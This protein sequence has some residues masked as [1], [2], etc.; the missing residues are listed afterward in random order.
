MGGSL[1]AALRSRQA[2]REVVGI[3]RRQSSLNTALTLQFVHRGT[4]DLREGVSQADIVV[5]CTPVGDILA[6]IAAISEWLKPG[7]LLMDVGS[8]KTA[9]CSAL[10]RLPAAV[11]PVGGHPMCGKESSGLTM[12]EPDLYQ[13][14][15]FVLCPLERTSSEARQLAEEL[16]RSVGARPTYLEPERHDRLVAAIS[17]LPAMLATTL[18]QTAA[19]LGQDDPLLWTLAAGGFRDTSRVAAGSVPMMMDILATNRDPI[20]HALHEAADQLGELIACLESGDMDTIQRTL[21]QA[22]ARRRRLYHGAAH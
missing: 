17:H 6:K 12:A 3:A 19:A 1:G 22:A 21:E 18:V 9:I 7:A 10:A 11:Q 20:L 5:L 15:V 4:T 16:V 13:D 8:T 14:R 2:C